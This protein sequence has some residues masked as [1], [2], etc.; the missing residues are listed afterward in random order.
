MKEKEEKIHRKYDHIHGV[1]FIFWSII[2]YL[3]IEPS[4]IFD[5]LRIFFLSLV[6][7]LPT[8]ATIFGFLIKSSELKMFGIGSAIIYIIY[9]TNNF[10]I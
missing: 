10:S 8:A 9:F 5:F 1:I 3:I 2:F 6:C 7:W 4:Q